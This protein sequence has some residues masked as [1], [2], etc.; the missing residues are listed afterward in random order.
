MTVI[1]GDNKVRIMALLEAGKKPMAIAEQ[2]G[3]KY[4]TIK[5][6][7]YDLK[8]ISTCPQRLKYTKGILRAV[9][10]SVSKSTSKRI[11]LLRIGKCV[12]LYN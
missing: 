3:F 11:Q 1:K 9:F 4:E 6:F 7:A 8:K 12:R 2:L 10:H 5:K